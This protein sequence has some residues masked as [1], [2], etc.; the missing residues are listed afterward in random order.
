MLRITT[1]VKA[2]NSSAAALA[3]VPSVAAPAIGTA[4]CDAYAGTIKIMGSVRFVSSASASAAGG[5]RG[6][7][8]ERGAKEPAFQAE[9]QAVEEQRDA[10]ASAIKPVEEFP[11]HPDLIAQLQKS[12]FKTLFPVQ[13][14]TLEHCLAG[15][16]VIVRARTGS[17]KTLGFAV[18][19][20]QHLL[21]TPAAQDP[22]QR[23]LPRAIVLAPTRELA[24]QVEEE[25]AKVLPRGLSST[26]IYGGAGFAQQESAL[27]RGVDVVVGTPG[28]IIDHLQRGTLDLSQ[29][30]FVVLDEA[31][32]ML[33]MGFK[34]DVEQVFGRT[35]DKRTCMLWSATVPRWV[36]TLASKY[37]SDPVMVDMVGDDESKIPD[38][39]DHTAVVIQ[40]ANIRGGPHGA[41]TLREAAVAMAIE[42]LAPQGPV[43]VFTSTK[44]QARDIC[45]K[46]RVPGIRMVS[47]EGDMSQSAREHALNSF[48]S[49]RAQVLVATDVAARGLDISSVRGVIHASVPAN[50]E[51]FVH[52]TGRTGR[53]GKS[54]SNVIICDS[55][56]RRMLSKY[57]NNLSID[58]AHSALSHLA[59]ALGKSASAAGVETGVPQ[60]QAVDTLRHAAK[61]A[62]AEKLATV[63]L[64]KNTELPRMDTPAALY[65]VLLEAMGGDAT[66]T[67]HALAAANVGAGASS[68]VSASLLSGHS[69][70]VTM[71]WVPPGPVRRVQGQHMEALQVAFDAAQLDGSGTW[72]P[73]SVQHKHTSIGSAVVDGENETDAGAA[74]PGVNWDMAGVTV[75]DVPA[76]LAERLVDSDPSDSLHIA[77]RL[78]ASVAKTLSTAFSFGSGGGGSRGF[79]GR[80]GRGGGGHRSGGGGG[81]YGGDRGRGGGGGGYGGDRGRGGGG[82]GFGGDRG[83]GGGGGS[84]YGGDRGRGGGGQ[85]RGGYSGGG[86]GSYGRK[87]GGFS[88]GGS[89]GGRGNVEW[90]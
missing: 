88:G 11:L 79:G 41:D 6:V 54:G 37:C 87:S 24:R 75:F 43:L 49:G 14:A 57:V 90:V 8:W 69:A 34:E 40:D 78:P 52:R 28:R 45:G 56:D 9:T 81:G 73:A 68:G 51:P 17:G 74:V 59:E 21:T 89:G 66:A 32:E 86:G 80:G 13:C 12:G 62:R 42:A 1:L 50:E 38:T 83:R 71:A 60:S 72:S 44:R 25:F 10:P 2:A 31:D 23:K 63:R 16:D 19:L 48:K 58:V 46:L 70:F 3:R 65:E 5:S 26:S 77:P 39:V 84:G 22:Y 55:E 30:E 29:C 33:N 7:S 61:Y 76:H 82:S 53:A 64:P 36:K 18:P 20:A 27:R 67:G 47:L 15:K 4:T 35:P 85:S